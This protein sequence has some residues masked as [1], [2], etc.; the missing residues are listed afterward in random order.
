MLIKT[1][2]NIKHLREAVGLTQSELAKDLSVTRASVNA[3]ELGTS[4]PSVERI[5]DLAEYFHTSTDFLLG[6]NDAQSIDISNLS[7]NEQEILYRLLH[8]FDI[9]KIHE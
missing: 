6:R 7:V 1:A 3:W 9:T 2:D 4:Y 8:Y 5:I